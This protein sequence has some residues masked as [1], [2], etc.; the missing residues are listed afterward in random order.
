MLEIIR[1]R[2]DY[3]N[4][5]YEDSKR[6]ETDADEYKATHA[7]KLKQT[8]DKCRR[9]FKKAV[10]KAQNKATD[11]IK[12]AKEN[13]RFEILQKKEKLVQE[14]TLLKQEVKHTVVKTLA[15]S[16]ASKILGFETVIEHSD[17]EPVDK[18]MD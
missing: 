5:N 4:S 9:E 17:Y 2:E 6:F 16:I 8:Q 7:S 1:K 3:I 13:S 15:S 11:K 14:E 12:M 10:E 18:A